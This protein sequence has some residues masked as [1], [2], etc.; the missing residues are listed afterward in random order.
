M[1]AHYVIWLICGS[2]LFRLLAA[3]FFSGV[4]LPHSFLLEVYFL[5]HIPTYLNLMHFETERTQRETK[6]AHSHPTSHGRWSLVFLNPSSPGPRRLSYV[7]STYDDGGRWT[8][9]ARFDGA[10]FRV[11]VC[12][13]A[14][15]EQIAPGRAMH[16][17]CVSLLASSFG[18]CAESN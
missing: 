7:C 4:W 2:F 1:F 14:H 17:L 10:S 15:T 11:H 12:I 18:L 6:N 9:M 16:F 8:L 13:F 5:S 3:R